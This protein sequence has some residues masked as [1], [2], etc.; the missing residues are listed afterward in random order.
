MLRR[1]PLRP[2]ARVGPRRGP[3]APDPRF[4]RRRRARRCPRRWR[5]VHRRR[6]DRRGLLRH[7]A[8]DG[9]GAR[10]AR[11]GR[12]AGEP[13]RGAGA[14]CRRRWPTCTRSTS[15]P[16]ASATSRAA[17]PTPERQLRR[18]TASG[19][20]PGRATT[21]A[22]T[23]RRAAG[24]RSRRRTEVRSSTATTGSTTWWSTPA[25]HRARRARLGALHARGSARRPRAADRL[26]A[27][28][29]PATCCPI[30]D[31]LLL[32]PG[33]PSRGEHGRGVR[34][35][36]PGARSTRCPFWIA[37]G[38]LEDRDHP[39]GHPTA[40]GSTSRRTGDRRSARSSRRSAASPIAPSSSLEAG[41]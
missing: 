33:I 9:T 38:L 13:S 14:R 27:E 29:S 30:H 37:L 5:A 1:P 22:S 2:A 19:R 16:S 11:G 20:R 36:R 28:S 15:T 23:R 4:A 24:P 32:L 31:E 40:A 25:G 17:T 41:W 7:G 18:W 12:R 21:R 34:A 6:R 10:R 35:R 39:A 8:V 26:H 3:R